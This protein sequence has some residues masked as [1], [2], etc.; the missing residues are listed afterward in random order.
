MHDEWITKFR[1]NPSEQ[2]HWHTGRY[3]GMWTKYPYPM[4]A[5]NYGTTINSCEV[6]RLR[7]KI[8]AK[9]PEA[10]RKVRHDE[11]DPLP[12]LHKLRG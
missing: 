2:L 5:P 10:I 1:E 3:E 9:P 4:V 8:S 6:E 7:R 12:V 11:S